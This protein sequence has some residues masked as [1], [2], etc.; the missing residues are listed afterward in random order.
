[1]SSA[2]QQIL[3]HFDPTRAAARRLSAAREVA[4]RLGAQLTALY[5]ATP[6]FVEL[7]Y[8]PNLG[9]GLAASLLEVDDRRRQQALKVFDET[10]NSPAAGGVH[11]VWAQTD[12]VPINETFA[13]QALFADLLVLGQRDLADEDAAAVPADFVET[14]LLAS[15][16]P[17]LV[18]PHIGATGPIGNTVAI[19]WKETPESARAVAAAMP[20]LRRAQK[21]YVMRWGEEREPEI[22]GHGLDLE[23]YLRAHGVDFTW[24]RTG[25][26]KQQI[27]ELLLSRAFD[28]GAD[29]LVMGCYGHSRAREWIMG[30]ASRTILQSM[31]LPVLMVH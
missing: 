31:T 10:M 25:A 19:A 28:F 14:V 27:G 17:G 7:P 11:A 20:F 13:R 23:Q 3:V 16:K 22:E 4:Q 1:V 9:P 29:L 21:V 12:Q 24:D 5:A 15:G 2:I 6:G 8:A 30:G 26:D 18:I